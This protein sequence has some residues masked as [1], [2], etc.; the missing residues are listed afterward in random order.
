MATHKSAEKRARQ[1]L[2]RR[3]RN[4]HFLT[5]M[6]N[7]I[8]EVRVMIADKTQDQLEPK[9]KEVTSTI[10][11]LVEKKIIHRNTGSRYVSRLSRQINNT[12]SK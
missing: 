11:K 5:R 8:R 2:K 4:K 6:R 9:L 1:S 12:H 3:N 7:I 10:Q